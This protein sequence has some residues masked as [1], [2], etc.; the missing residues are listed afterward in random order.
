MKKKRL[1]SFIIMNVGIMIAGL[2]TAFF[3]SPYN[4]VS[5][6]VTGIAIIM[7]DFLKQYFSIFILGTNLILLSISYFF[8][9]KTYFIKSLYGSISY[10]LY[11]A[12]FQWI[13]EKL[14]IQ[15]VDLFLV[16]LFSGILM[17]FGLGL[18]FK[19]GSSTGG[20]DIV[21][22]ILFKK[23]NIPYSK[24]L[25]VVDGIIILIGIF[26]FGFAGGL[27]AI[28]YM[29]IS[30]QIMDNVIFG[31]FN[32]RAVY[33]I[34]P[35]IEKVKTIILEKLERGATKI[36]A[37]G[38]YNDDLR[39]IILCVLSTNEYFVLRRAI[40]KI[41]PTAFMFVTKATEV[42]GLGFSYDSQEEMVR[43]DK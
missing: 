11:I 17:G 30:G 25:Y 19:N 29:Y 38:A 42:L 14:P 15:N 3:L 2:T 6:G 36:V 5:G 16:V 12:L 35:E 4:I 27:A 31:G 40:E 21:Q 37:R 28:C 24:T 8:M 34:T 10:P 26:K 43:N 13:Y 33:I 39:D 18:S 7:Q 9:G 23:F 32:K 1:K 20:V 41:D 22:A